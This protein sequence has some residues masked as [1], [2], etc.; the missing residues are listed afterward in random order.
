[1]TE[2]QRESLNSP[3]LNQLLAAGDKQNDSRFQADAPYWGPTSY[4]DEPEP[5][6]LERALLW[7]G[8]YASYA[9]GVIALIWLATGQPS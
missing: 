4:D 3:Y 5:E 6:G 8:I 7:A 2:S 1:M 9:I